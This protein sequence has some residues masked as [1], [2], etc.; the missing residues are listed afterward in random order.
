MPT[1][2]RLMDTIKTGYKHILVVTV[3]LLTA[4]FIGA[5]A[6]GGEAEP[7]PAPVVQQ[8]D[9]Q[10]IAD[11]VKA[12][13]EA[14]A[15][16]SASP[17]EIQAM[18]ENAVMAASAGDSGVSAEQVQSIVSKAVESAAASGGAVDPQLISDAVK[19]V[20]EASAAE[21][22]SPEE[23]QA[24]VEKAVMAAAGDSASPEEIQAM[25]EKP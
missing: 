18:V 21:S 13:I 24:M 12:V 19:A 23:I 11:A 25:M 15:A 1:R 9:P 4:A 22:A 16:E 5:V 10:M 8:V 14:S 2:M 3:A 7:G 17:E 6:C 20:V